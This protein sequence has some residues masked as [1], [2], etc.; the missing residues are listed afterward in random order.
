MLRALRIVGGVALMLA[1]AWASYRLLPHI[2]LLPAFLGVFVGG[3]LIN[4]PRALA[5]LRERQKDIAEYIE[6]RPEA[7]KVI[8]NDRR[9]R[10]LEAGLYVLTVVIFGGVLAFEYRPPFAVVVVMVLP[11]I[12]AVA[13]RLRR[14]LAMTNV[15]VRAFAAKTEN[16]ARFLGRNVV[17]VGVVLAIV[18]GGVAYT[19]DDPARRNL[20]VQ[21]GYAMGIVAFLGT[22]IAGVLKDQE[23]KR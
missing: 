13:S 2:E 1:G 6:A 20:L 12:F 7:Q 18:I 11:I 15:W 5:N 14:N 22:V 19:A 23:E 10:Q 16:P 21:L 8:Q 17:L 9:G 3:M 4:A